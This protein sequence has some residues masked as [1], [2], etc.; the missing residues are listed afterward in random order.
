MLKGTKYVREKI[1]E[2]GLF[3][4]DVAVIL[5]SGLRKITD[6]MII[7]ID[8]NYSDIP[9]MKQ[10]TVEDHNGKFIIGEV[11]NYEVLAM[12]GRI[13]YYETGDMDDV[14][15]PINIIEQL[16]CES[17]VITDIVG[18]VNENYNVG[19]VFITEDHINMMG[20]N[21]LINENIN[22]SI[23]LDQKNVYNKDLINICNDIADKNHIESYNGVYFGIAG[24]NYTTPAELKM[25]RKMGGDVVGMATIPESIQANKLGLDVVSLSVIGSSSN[26]HKNIKIDQE[27][28]D[29]VKHNKFDLN[30]MLEEI[31]DILAKR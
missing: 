25:V 20:S 14:I 21:P 19:S 23:F 16:G 8:I 27:V 5:S 15:R 9:G 2:N 17:L 24:P 3:V 22:S 4:P 12:D 18:S 6:S 10:A 7:Q 13:H 26:T 29:S 1:E 11:G 30:L 31:T 28:M